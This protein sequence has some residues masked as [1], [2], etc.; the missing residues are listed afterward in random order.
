MAGCGEN[1]RVRATPQQT[2][3]RVEIPLSKFRDVAVPYHIDLL[4]KHKVNIE[5]VRLYIKFNL[6]AKLV[7]YILLSIK[8]LLSWIH[9]SLI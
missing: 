8:F 7:V 5:K 6:A 1:L 3:K 2:L 4:K 9:M